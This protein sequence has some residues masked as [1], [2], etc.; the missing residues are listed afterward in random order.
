MKTKKL[1]C[2]PKTWHYW[3]HAWQIW[4]KIDLFNHKYNFTLSVTNMTTNMTQLTMQVIDLTTFPLWVLINPAKSLIHAQSL[5][6]CA[7]AYDYHAQTDQ[8]KKARG[9]IAVLSRSIIRL[10]EAAHRWYLS[11]T[12]HQLANFLIINWQTRKIIGF[13][14]IPFDL[15]SRHLLAGLLFF[16]RETTMMHLQDVCRVSETRYESCFAFVSFLKGAR[17]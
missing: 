3:P 14:V 17:I 2:W 1:T 11:L 5:H 9:G 13:I 10:N 6:T 15:W 8:S 7:S 12:R 16:G 4:Q